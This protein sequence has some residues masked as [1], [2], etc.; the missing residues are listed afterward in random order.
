MAD[1]GVCCFLT[2]LLCENKSGS[3]DVQRLSQKIGWSEAQ[4]SQILQEAGPERFLL[5]ED[6]DP[7]VA[8][9]VAVSPL[10]LCGYYLRDECDGC[11][12]LHLCKL[13][14]Q[15]RCRY[16]KQGYKCR[17]SHDIHLPGNSKILK[18]NALFGINESELKVLLFQNDPSLLPEVCPFYNRGEGPHGSC[19]LQDNCT[20]LH[21]CKHFI[22]GECRFQKCKRSH[23]LHTEN[24][25]KLLR[26]QGLNA[27]T[28]LNI[29]RICKFKHGEIC[30]SFDKKKDKRSES[31]STSNEKTK[32][33]EICLYYI[34]KFCKQKNNCRNVHYKLP[35]RWQ[36]LDGTVW[37]DLPMM[38]GIEKIYCDPKNSRY[39]SP[40]P[41]PSSPSYI[42]LLFNL[43]LGLPPLFPNV[44]AQMGD[45][46]INFETMTCGLNQVRRLSTPS[47]V[48]KPSGILLTTTWLWY[49]LN[50]N[51]QWI[52]YGTQG[53]NH[54][55]S[56]ITSTDIETI[57]LADSHSTVDFQAGHQ[58]YEI[59]FK[60]MVQKNLICQT[61]RKICRRPKFVSAED[62]DKLRKRNQAEGSRQGAFTFAVPPSWDKSAVPD[63]GYKL[64]MLNETSKEFNDVKSQF[65]KT[66]TGFVIQRIQRI[67]NLA[68]WQVFQWQK[69][70]MKKV[71]GGK[72][73]DERHLF[74]GTK[75]IHLNDICSHNFDWRICGTH[76]TVYGK[77]SYFAR[78][79]SY[80]HNYSESETN[81]KIMFLARVLVGVFTQ[82]DSKYV[83]PPMRQGT[84]NTFY[85][86]CVNNRLDPTIFVI[87]EKHQI[88]PEYVI[89]YA[90]KSK[91]CTIS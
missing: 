2:K 33:S 45:L 9:A 18:N 86:S 34:W 43:A 22:W 65:E 73:V 74:H 66:M 24:A 15:D 87:F 81:V 82:G 83:R 29:Q 23:D 51:G 10:R 63:V 53:E 19:N 38:E 77:G 54:P 85:D 80:S 1:P 35:Y 20:K 30:K 44:G 47:S 7:S 50:D 71:N 46:D 36:K 90:E 69:E 26:D 21:V 48:T 40:A 56:S 37:N 25:M 67:Q 75:Y 88:Y 3:S 64:V 68:L 79:A 41:S 5:V 28:I 72:D 17:F 49:W 61:K 76:A 89:E 8:V 78:D 14:V 11:E 62:V 39:V 57:Y 42:S 32:S 70:Q 27:S 52:E 31:A 12:R 4:L 60:E 6:E 13:F 84:Q 16:K 58:F 91:Q 59:N 55:P